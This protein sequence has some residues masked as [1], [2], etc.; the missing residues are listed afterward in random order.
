MHWLL[1]S[2]AGHSL[3][4]A[5]L[6]EGIDFDFVTELMEYQ[7]QALTAILSLALPVTLGHFFFSLLLSGGALTS[8]WQERPYAGARF[9]GD[10]SRHFGPFLRLALWSALLLAV[11]I[12]VRLLLNAAIYLAAGGDPYE[13]TIYWSLVIQ[14]GLLGLAV[15]L[16][17]L[18]VDY[19]RIHL[20]ASGQRS[21]GRALLEGIRFSLANLPRTASLC[22]LFLLLSGMA[23][24]FYLVVSDWIDAPQGISVAGL[25]L[26]QQLYILW[27][28]ALRLARYGS[29]ISLR[30]AL[31]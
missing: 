19:G 21:S 8:L 2:F 18:F 3:E 31:T 28:M 27:R 15:L 10:A 20:V 13:S 24:L 5:R 17:S 11:L 26:L 6:A 25:I 16:I 1:S 23:G 9:W 14:A 30:S 29:E 22:I 7:P 12:V 4:G